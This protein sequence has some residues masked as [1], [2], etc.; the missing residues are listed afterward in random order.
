MDGMEEC[1]ALPILFLNIALWNKD[2]EQILD[3]GFQIKS[4]DLLTLYVIFIITPLQRSFNWQRWDI[5][6]TQVQNSF[7][8]LLQQS[9]QL[10]A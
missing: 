7:L 6:G 5:T 1:P 3:L 4:L 8:F 2:S 10:K 9:K